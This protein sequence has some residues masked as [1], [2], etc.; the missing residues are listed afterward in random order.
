MKTTEVRKEPNT[1]V[2]GLKTEITVYRK[3]RKQKTD[4][5]KEKT[6]N[7]PVDGQ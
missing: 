1:S 5:E 6:E 3:G 2:L 7:V 4:T